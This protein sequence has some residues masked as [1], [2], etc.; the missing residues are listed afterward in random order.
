MPL[1]L[2]TLPKDSQAVLSKIKNLIKKHRF[3]L[4]GGTGLAIQIG[5]RVSEDLDFFTKET[6]ST[7]RLFQEIK[8]KALSPVVLQEEKGTLTVTAQGVKLSFLQYTYPF[9]EKMADLDGVPIA[10]I[11]DITSMKIVAVS[12]RGAKRDF[13]DLY[14]VL[15][16]VPFWKI[17]ENLME[18]FGADRVNPVH[19]GKSLVY[20]QDADIDPD[21]LYLGSDQPAWDQ[22][23]KFF[24]KNVK[25]MVMDLDQASRE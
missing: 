15:Q 3:V 8:G 21:P 1:H 24:K 2:E 7:D 16:T 20:F 22:V 23:K 11:I 14:A 4:A 12:Q 18:R 10:G 13:V 19:I 25:Q 9:K 6:F 5:H 17:A